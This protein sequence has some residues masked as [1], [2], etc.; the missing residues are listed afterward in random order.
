MLFEVG[1]KIEILVGAATP[2]A[3]WPATLP[4]EFLAR[5]F[6]WT[7]KSNAVRSEV[8]QGPAYQRPRYSTSW[9]MFTAMMVIDGT[10]LDTFT[11]W[12][13]NDLAGGALPF[14]HDHPLTG[15][16]V[17]MRFDVSEEPKVQAAAQ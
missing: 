4:G 2:T 1:M 9:I 12:Y 14:T 15:E 10:Q 13:L 11:S 6:S 5:G 8:D 7:P 17:V 3:S 16:T